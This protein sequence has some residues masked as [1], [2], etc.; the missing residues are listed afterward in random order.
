MCFFSKGHLA[1][2][3]VVKREN[4]S[5]TANDAKGTCTSKINGM[6]V[7]IAVYLLYM[8]CTNDVHQ[9]FLSTY[10]SLAGPTL[11]RLF[12]SHEPFLCFIIVCI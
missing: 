5:L 12:V 1:L 9:Q 7:K 10:G 3:S 2:K 6:L 8:V 4:I 11:A